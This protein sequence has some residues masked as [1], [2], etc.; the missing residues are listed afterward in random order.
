MMESCFLTTGVNVPTAVAADVTGLSRICAD[1]LSRLD[2]F[3]RRLDVVKD[4]ISH[5]CE[6]RQLIDKV[7]I[8]M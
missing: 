4:N 7:L 3:V 6:C 1:L 2:E 5:T 8:S